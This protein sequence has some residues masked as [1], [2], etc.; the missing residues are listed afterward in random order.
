MSK[1]FRHNK[2]KFEISKSI[3]TYTVR[4]KRTQCRNIF[5]NKHI[6]DNLYKLGVECIPNKKDIDY[7][8]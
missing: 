1:T 7:W 5:T 8:W 4:S 6:D 3:K 2:T